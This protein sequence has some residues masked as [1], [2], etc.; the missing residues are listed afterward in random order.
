MLSN[1]KRNAS[2]LKRNTALVHI[3]STQFNKKLLLLKYHITRE[4]AIENTNIFKIPPYYKLF[5]VVYYMFFFFY[6]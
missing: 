4:E 5:S 6:L 2:F 3:F 1:K